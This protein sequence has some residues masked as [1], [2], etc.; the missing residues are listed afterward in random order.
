MASVNVL[1]HQNVARQAL[2]GPTFTLEALSVETPQQ[3]AAVVAE[4]GASV[5]VVLE[6]MRHVDLEALLLELYADT[7]WPMFHDI[8]RMRQPD[9][10]EKPSQRSPAITSSC[11]TQSNIF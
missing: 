10:L 4:R 7:L 5:V 6:A 8:R 11:C 1:L 3:A 9:R 2:S